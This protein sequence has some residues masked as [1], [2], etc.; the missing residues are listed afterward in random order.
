MEWRSFCLYWETLQ[1]IVGRETAKVG[2]GKA[3]KEGWI[4]KDKDTFKATVSL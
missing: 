1:G 4:R 2:Q 3:L